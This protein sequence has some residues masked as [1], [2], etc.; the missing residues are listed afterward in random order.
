MAIPVVEQET[1][2][3]YNR[4]GET[5]TIYTTDTTQMTK[6]DK[7]YPRH[8]EHKNGGEVVAVEYVVDKGLVSYRSKRMK[9]S[10][11][12]E[13]KAAAS[14]RLKARWEKARENMA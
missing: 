3:Q 7:I 8:K 13:Q 2:V 14:A 11:T 5:A 9:N 1:V 12:K 10:M 6:L 4:D